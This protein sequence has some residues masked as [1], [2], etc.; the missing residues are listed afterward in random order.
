MYYALS[1]MKSSR[2]DTI[3]YTT[4]LLLL[5][6]T[7]SVFTD[8]LI[9]ISFFQLPSSHPH[10]QTLR[11]SHITIPQPSKVDNHLLKRDTRRDRPQIQR[12]CTPSNVRMNRGV[13]RA[14]VTDH[15][16]PRNAVTSQHRRWDGLDVVNRAVVNTNSVFNWI[17]GI[18]VQRRAHGYNDARIRGGLVE[19]E[20]VVLQHR[21]ARAIGALGRRGWRQQSDAGEGAAVVGDYGVVGVS[22]G[23]CFVVG[24]VLGL[25][26]DDAVGLE[27]AGVVGGE[28]GGGVV[29]GEEDF[30]DV[31]LGAVAKRFAC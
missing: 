5:L 19:A 7:P 14:K 24:E 26:G 27:E 28:A 30:G 18:S 12:V 31:V 10:P 8:F 13:V 6:L 3:L 2:H 21:G 16:R 29:E 4:N 1:G 20:E 25:D 15:L 11:R 23:G 17:I 22:G 9:H